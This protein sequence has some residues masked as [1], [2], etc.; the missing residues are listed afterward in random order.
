MGKIRAILILRISLL[1]A[2]MAGY[3]FAHAQQLTASITTTNN[4]KASFSQAGGNLPSACYTL[5]FKVQI[6]AGGNTTTIVCTITNVKQQQPEIT[7]A[8][9]QVRTSPT[10]AWQNLP[11]NQQLNAVFSGTPPNGMQRLP[12]G[13]NNYEFR[14]E[15]TRTPNLSTQPSNRKLAD[16]KVDAYYV[17]AGTPAFATPH[18]GTIDLGSGGSGGTRQQQGFAQQQR[19]SPISWNG[20]PVTTLRRKFNPKTGRVELA[21]NGIYSRIGYLNLKVKNLNRRQSLRNYRFR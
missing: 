8:R 3:D 2:V 9:V 13:L 19:G 7:S 14:I 11:P 16:Y 21:K 15:F 12:A 18:N 17:A 4:W 10:G 6:S 1:F 20:P 5:P